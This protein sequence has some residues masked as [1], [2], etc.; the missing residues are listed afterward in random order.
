M[1]CEWFVTYLTKAPRVS[2]SVYA[3]SSPVG[4]LL[5]GIAMELWGR[6]SM[7]IIGNISMAMG[8]LLI[9]FAQNTAMIINGRIAEGISRSFIATS[10]TVITEIF[11]Q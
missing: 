7:N 3:I 4:C 9:T 1:S 5:G 10:I 8:W 2:A 6:R 11:F